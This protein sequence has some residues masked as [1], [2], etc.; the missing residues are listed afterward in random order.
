MKKCPVLNYGPSALAE[1]KSE[2]IATWFTLNKRRIVDGGGDFRHEIEPHSAGAS[3][4]HICS[5]WNIHSQ[6]RCNFTIFAETHWSLVAEAK[7]LNE[8]A[9]IGGCRPIFEGFRNPA[10]PF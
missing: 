9:S 4:K 7:P 5:P 1:A 8:G 3:M 6:Q 2:S 10:E